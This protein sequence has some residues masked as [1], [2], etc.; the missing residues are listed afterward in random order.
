MDDI[1][2][3]E[4]GAAQLSKREAVRR[5]E[6]PAPRR[7]DACVVERWLGFLGHRWNALIVWHL[8]GGPKRH[9]ALAELLPGVAPKVLA[10]RLDGLCRAGLL[11]RTEAAAFP[12]SV[13]YG[14]TD[15]GQALMPILD[16][17]DVWARSHG[18]PGT[19][20]PKPLR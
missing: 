9:G 7:P 1:A 10:E 13:R 6:T 20:A 19:N 5:A 17:L 16:R 2:R 14:L 11:V 15:Q 3:F 8:R 4:P 12:R 18:A